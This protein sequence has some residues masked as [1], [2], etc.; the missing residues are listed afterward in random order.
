[1]PSRK[2]N[3][4]I[5]QFTSGNNQTLLKKYREVRTRKARKQNLFACEKDG[6]YDSSALT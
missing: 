2:L 3:E 1:M 6:W 4:K 5:Y